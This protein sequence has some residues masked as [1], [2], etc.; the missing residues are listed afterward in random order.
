MNIPG[1]YIRFHKIRKNNRERH[2][3][4]AQMPF[5]PVGHFFTADAL[6]PSKTPRFKCFRRRIELEGNRNCK[7]PA[8]FCRFEWIRR[9]VIVYIFA[10]IIQ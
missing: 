9:S 3:A 8:S 4:G 6:N 10:N 7:A 5:F 1:L 2:K